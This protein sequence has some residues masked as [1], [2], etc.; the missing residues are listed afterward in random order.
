MAA[1]SLCSLVRKARAGL[2]SSAL[3]GV[4]G[5][6]QLRGMTVLLEWNGY[7]WH[8]NPHGLFQRLP[9]PLPALLITKAFLPLLAK[10]VIL[11]VMTKDLKQ[12]KAVVH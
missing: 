1:F 6:A 12:T 8:S 11:S 4:W 7:L 3:D 5:L 10:R 2:A 9:G